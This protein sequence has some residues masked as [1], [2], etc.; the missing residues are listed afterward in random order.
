MSISV[1]PCLGIAANCGKF[2]FA[3]FFAVFP[4]NEIPTVNEINGLRDWP[5]YLACIYRETTHLPVKSRGC[6]ASSP[7][8]EK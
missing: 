8:F 1:H 6:I 3:A 2:E 5:L 7:L 4:E